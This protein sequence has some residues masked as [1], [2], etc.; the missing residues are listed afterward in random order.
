MGR[1]ARIRSLW[2]AQTRD[3]AVL[4]AKRMEKTTFRCRHS[5][6][7][8]PDGASHLIRTPSDE[9]P[10]LLKNKS[11][12]EITENGPSG[13]TVGKNSRLTPILEHA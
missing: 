12:Q 5:R 1:A 11:Q 2:K 7:P 3:S 6:N 9:G 4:I 10:F 8:R 13:F